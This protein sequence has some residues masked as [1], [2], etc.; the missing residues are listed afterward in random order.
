M[1]FICVIILLAWWS[2]LHIAHPVFHVSTIPSKIDQAEFLVISFGEAFEHKKVAVTLD[3]ANA[4]LFQNIRPQ[5]LACALRA[6]CY[7]LVVIVRKSCG[8]FDTKRF[9][10]NV[11]ESLL[12]WI[13]AYVHI[14]TQA[15][16]GYPP[17]VH[18]SDCKCGGSL[19]G[20]RSPDEHAGC[21]DSPFSNAEDKGLYTSS[22]RHQT[23][24]LASRF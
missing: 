3:L 12:T 11:G 6:G 4:G 15:F 23:I 9:P 7:K 1:V 2:H 13:N 14:L 21:R 18:R 16:E 8:S 19:K 10:R 20:N 5:H 22:T 24:C 17:I